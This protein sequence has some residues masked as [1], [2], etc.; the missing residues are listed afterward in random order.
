MRS[1]TGCL[2]CRQRKLKCDERKPVCGPCS[3][4]SRDCRFGSSIIFRHQQNA[5]MNGTGD[6]PDETNLKSFFAY[7]NTFDAD[8]VWLDIPRQV[9]FWN[10]TDPYNEPMSP[11]HEAPSAS[12]SA[13]SQTPSQPVATVE[14]NQD[15]YRQP[16]ATS[17]AHGLH[18]LSAAAAGDHFSF[19][20]RDSAQTATPGSDNT[21]LPSVTPAMQVPTPLARRSIDPPM[22]PPVSMTSSNHNIDFILNHPAA[23]SPTLDP[24]L[25]SPFASGSRE[26]FHTRP[27]SSHTSVTATSN[28]FEIN[29]ETDHEIAYLLR[30]FSEGPGQWMDLYDLGSYFATYVPVKAQANPVLKHAAA[31]YAA[32]ALGRVRGKKPRSGGNAFR[33]A[34]MELYPNSGAVDWYHKAAEYYDSAVSLLRQAIQDDARGMSQEATVPDTN[35]QQQQQQVSDQAE[36]DGGPYKRRRLSS[37]PISRCNSDELLAATAI[38]C[39]YEFL[40]G[41][42]HEWSRHLNGAKSLI[43]IAKDSM[44]PLQL[45]SPGATLLHQSA[46]LSKARKA[47][48]WNIA[49][50]DMLSAFINASHTRLD[51][52][53][54][55][56]W[57]DAGLLIDASGFVMLPENALS[58]YPERE[59]TMKEDMIAN[60]LVWLMAKLVNFMAAGD[61]LPA[62]VSGG[63]PYPTGVPQRT[64]LDYWLYLKQQFQTWHDGLPVTFKACAR[65]PPS[66]IP[67]QLIED[68]SD[69]VFPEVWYSL[70]MCG[71][72]MQSYHMSQIQLLMNKPHETTQGRTTVFARFNSYEAAIHE[73]QK[74]SREIVSI[75][76]GRP[77]NAVRINSVQPLYTAG[78]CLAERRERRVVAR[79]L[80]EVERD[81][82]WATEYRRRMLFEQWGEGW[83]DEEFVG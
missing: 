27:T 50:Q 74:H 20:A 71:S 41:S 40:D 47:T 37:I 29:A 68:E 60:A 22:S 39:V 18:A 15:A 12:T 21:L 67:A 13:T 8:T 34:R 35:W 59:D 55:P 17:A 23:A 3:K 1:R 56:M 30:Y 28:P 43:D 73:C 82:G 80:R 33:P 69:A 76:L 38:L 65:I 77:D 53:D 70:P 63:S 62:S 11:D 72:T 9:T 2:T 6:S 4:A 7:K 78:Q 75:A 25:Q 81:T 46:K 79:L 66:R 45:P 57:K 48:F 5:S 32:K 42:G 14:W 31:A 24:T 58:G 51:P 10:T 54:L 52:E 36:N 16:D 19:L 49:R 83:G 44:M 64:L 26:R 61:E